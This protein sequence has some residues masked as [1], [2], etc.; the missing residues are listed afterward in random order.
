MMKAGYC[1]PGPVEPIGLEVAAP[2][3]RERRAWEKH[4]KETQTTTVATRNNAFSL[5]KFS[6]HM[7]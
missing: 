5:Q 7:M 3:E 6:I 1:P 2:A 4:G